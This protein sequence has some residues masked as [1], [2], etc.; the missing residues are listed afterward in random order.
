MSN[1]AKFNGSCTKMNGSWRSTN[2]S[3]SSFNDS[4]KMEESKTETNKAGSTPSWLRREAE[5]ARVDDW[6]GGFSPAYI[7]SYRQGRKKTI[8]IE[9]YNTAPTKN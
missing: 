2:D 1:I 5:T 8:E 4:W 7:H 3:A 6:V 9:G